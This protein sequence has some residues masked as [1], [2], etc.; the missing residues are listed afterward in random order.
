MIDEAPH[1]QPL[2]FNRYS[3]CRIKLIINFSLLYVIKASSNWWTLFLPLLATLRAFD[4]C[5]LVLCSPQMAVIVTSTLPSCEQ[6]RAIRC[7]LY[8]FQHS[9]TW[10]ADSYHT[11]TSNYSRGGSIKRQHF[12]F[13][14]F[15][16][17]FSCWQ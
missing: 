17:I 8:A 16:F 6:H 3:L 13:F 12:H 10:P 4:E 15:K 11:D 2:K 9:A 7:L 5:S 14:S 1:D